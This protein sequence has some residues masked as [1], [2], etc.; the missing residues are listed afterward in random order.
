[1]HGHS[2]HCWPSDTRVHTLPALAVL[3]LQH[4]A[5]CCVTCRLYCTGY[6]HCRSWLTSHVS[7]HAL[8]K[9]V[10]V[11]QVKPSICPS[12]FVLSCGLPASKHL[13]LGGESR[14]PGQRPRWSSDL[15]LQR[16]LGPMAI[17]LRLM[18]NFLTL[19]CH[20]CLLYCSI[21]DCVV[22]GGHR[23]CLQRGRSMPTSVAATVSL[24]LIT[25]TVP[26]KDLTHVC[27]CFHSTK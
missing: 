15:L 2:V 27:C 4:Q 16:G 17:L 24:W 21:V 8:V 3:V 18:D 10:S 22:R 25:H 11:L 7:V 12:M 6:K 14:G 9:A 19:L 20:R 1:M 5:C 13:V 26:R 23:V